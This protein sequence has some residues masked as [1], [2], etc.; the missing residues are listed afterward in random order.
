M[1]WRTIYPQEISTPLLQSYLQSV[2]APRP[3]AFVSTVDKKGNI[4]LSPF[5]FFN[6]FSANPP[7]V[8]FSPSR[9]VRDNTTKHTLENAIEVPEVV[10]NMV[11]YSMVEQTSLASTEY[12]K[13]VNEF[14]KAGLTPEPSVLV[15]PPRAS[16]SPAALECKVKQ[17]IPLGEQGGA[18]NLVICEVLL[19]HLKEDIFDENDKIS[20]YKIDLVAR[21]GGDWYSRSQGEMLFEVPK[22]LQTKGIGVDS[23]PERI[24]NSTV[25]TGNNLGRLGNVE[26]L[27]SQAEIDEFRHTEEM[28]A[29][30]HKFD[31][32]PVELEKAV[33][34]LAQKYLEKKEILTAWKVLL[35]I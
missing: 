16:E 24:R 23:I 3:I 10:I 15:K 8:I 6:L 18:G 20:P 32:E 31:N 35:S 33:H 17:I 30:F 9:K 22:P 21:M 13:G 26:R 14:I 27:P 12:E 5:S 19:I 25:L 7:I 34:H 1:S 29:L 11:N 4:N 2:V 28:K